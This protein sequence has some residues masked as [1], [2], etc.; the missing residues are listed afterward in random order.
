MALSSPGEAKTRLDFWQAVSA[1]VLA[2]FVCAQ[3]AAATNR[4]ARCTLVQR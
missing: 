1:A 2:L 3:G 4:T